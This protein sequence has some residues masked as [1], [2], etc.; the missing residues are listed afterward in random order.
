MNFGPIILLVASLV[1]IPVVLMSGAAGAD[2]LGWLL[3]RDAE[4]RH[5]GSDLIKLNH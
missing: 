3:G 4:A 5:D 2:A 1:A